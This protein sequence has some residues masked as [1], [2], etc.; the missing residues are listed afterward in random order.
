MVPYYSLP[1]FMNS[2]SLVVSITHLLT[3]YLV[4]SMFDFNTYIHMV[5]IVPIPLDFD[6]DLRFTSI[7]EVT[8]DRVMFSYT[9]FIF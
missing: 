9:A 1:L 8:Q 4:P 2:F 3:T 7:T 5:G 6:E